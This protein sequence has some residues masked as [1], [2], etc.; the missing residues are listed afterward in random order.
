MPANLTPEYMQADAEFRK[1]QT[2]EERLACL[3][4]MLSV[5]PKHKST[6]RL[7]A[8]LKTKIRILKEE[9]EESKK[10]PKKT[11]PS[12]RFVRQGAGQY[13]LL[14]APNSGKS[15]LMTRLTRAPAE[16][17][18]YPFSTRE[19][20]AGM[21]DWEDARVQLID[22]PPITS[23]FMESYLSSL[24]RSADAAMLVADLSDDEGVFSAQTI[25]DRLAQTKTILMGSVPADSTD[26]SLEYVRTFVVANK[27]DCAE[28]GRRLEDLKALFSERFAIYAVSAEMGTNVDDLRNQI[29]QFL[30][31][32]RV[33]T[34]EPGKPP[35]MKT[36]YTCPEGS[37]LL[38]LAALVHRDF[39]LNLKYARIWGTGVFAG[40]TVKRDH[41]LHDKDVV[42]LHI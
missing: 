39:A 30:N 14:G 22:T 11:G 33:Y 42:E 9:I 8:D 21:M 20:C 4:R 26:I 31:V 2:P 34:K 32:I 37:S 38:D 10:S 5:I 35:D 18:P 19:P 40:Q 41:V 36:P 13:V 17:A 15:R 29:Y 25:I 24:V 16:V 28:A 1:A 7:Q 23:D 6:E 12:Y 3:K 27:L